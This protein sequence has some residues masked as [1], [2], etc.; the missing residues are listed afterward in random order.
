MIPNFTM[1]LVFTV[2]FIFLVTSAFAQERAQFMLTKDGFISSADSSKNYIVMQFPGKSKDELFKRALTFLNTQFANPDRAISKVDGESITINGVAD[3]AVFI[4][5]LF[6]LGLN[7][8]LNYTETIEFKD[9]RIRI[10]APSIN[11]IYT[12]TNNT[13]TSIH[14]LN[15][16]EPGAN[17]RDIFSKNGKVK[18]ESAKV[19]LEN[20]FAAW[21]TMLTNGIGKP[22]D[23]W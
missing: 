16:Y 22:N 20:Y 15:G 12:Y 1:K 6:G 9:G 13:V 14:L 7:Y 17:N 3:N 4:K 23:N 10:I 2:L 18:I 19:N 5:G 21:N 8:N 11:R